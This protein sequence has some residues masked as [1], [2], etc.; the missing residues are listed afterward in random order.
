MNASLLELPSPSLARC[1]LRGC[2]SGYLCT[3]VCARFECHNILFAALT[4]QFVLI[5]ACIH[6]WKLLQF[7]LIN[8][9]FPAR[10]CAYFPNSEV[11]FSA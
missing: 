2:M 4:S 5:L 1:D 6:R 10:L 3:F 7:S 9:E 8:T 11:D